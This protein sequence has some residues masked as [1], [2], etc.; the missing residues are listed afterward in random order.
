MTQKNRKIEEDDPLWPI[1]RKIKKLE[2]S[3]R[4]IKEQNYLIIIILSIILLLI[5]LQPIIQK[6]NNV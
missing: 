5:I 3:S 4:K 6:F 1:F 2:H